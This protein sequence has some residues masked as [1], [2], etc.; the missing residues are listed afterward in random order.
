MRTA[1]RSSLA[2]A[3]LLIAPSAFFA[4]C[5]RTGSPEVVV[6]VSEDQVFSEP[7]LKDFER[8]TG[9]TVRAVFDTEEAKSTGVMN[10]LLAEERNP[11]ADVYWANEPIRAEA[12]KLKAISAPY[13]SPNANGIPPPFRDPEHHWTG[14]SASARLLI[15][16]TSVAQRPSSVS[17]YLDPQFAGRAAI[18]NPLFGTTT[19]HAAALFALWGEAKA[20]AFFDA[21]KANHVRVTTS[22]GD[23]ADL[24]AEGESDFALVDSDDA[25]NRQKQGRPVVAVVPDQ[26]P[27]QPGV[28]L[29]PNVA[30]LVKGAPHAENGR[31]LI[32]TCSR[33]TRSENS[34]SPIAPRSRSTL[35]S[36]RRRTCRGS[37]D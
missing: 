3:L 29:L 23:S 32:D 37:R 13:A 17:A 15:V 33:R 14:F 16:N 26:T 20:N 35:E 18:A 7:I 30:L 31:K 4:G 28:L 34:H 5:L 22:N 11:Q 12:L 19:A 9:I 1:A 21:M 2:A 27:D 8:E 36:R 25:F 6:Y 24:V 10:R